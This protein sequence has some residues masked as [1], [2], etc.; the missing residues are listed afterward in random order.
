MR[1]PLLVQERK[2]QDC[3]L[4]GHFVF[5]ILSDDQISD[6]NDHK[7]CTVY[8]KGQYLF[9]ENS[10]PTGLFC[11]YSGKIKLTTIGLDGKE[12]IIR[13]AK[14][15]DIIGY[16][17]LLT[18]ERYRLS[19][20]ALEDCAVCVIDKD[21]FL[22]LSA[23]EP[24][25]NQRIFKLISNDLKKAEEHI[26]SLSQ[27]NVRERMAE[28]LLFLK[29]TYGF[30]GDGIT[31]N[32]RLSREELADYIGTATESVIRLL[33]EFNA[34]GIIELEGK[35]IRIRDNDRLIRTANIPL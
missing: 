19:A 30:E 11:V 34:A 16:R 12:Q 8:R 27:K 31:I 3:T 23:R 4:R 21:F 33:S 2:C 28:A 15:R 22:E 17:A 26:V 5:S 29:A 6:L 35:K 24:K 32:V 13:L 9:T 14:D 25:L 10:R 1:V 20:I 18:D 7:A